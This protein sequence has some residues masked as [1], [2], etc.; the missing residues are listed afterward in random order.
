M[1]ILLLA[2]TE[3]EIAPTFDRLRLTAIKKDEKVFQTT[4]HLVHPLITGIGAVATT[5][6]LCKAL[7]ERPDV[8]IQAGV[9]GAFDFSMPLGTVV[10]VRT[11]VFADLAVEESD[12]HLKD[13]FKLGLL[14]PDEAPYSGQVL[15]NPT[16]TL[17]KNLNQVNGLT[18]QTVHGQ[19]HSIAA[20]RKRYPG[21][22]VESMEGAALFYGCILEK[23]PFFQI[24]AIS[25][26][27]EPR[28]REK[29][30]MEKAI[31]NLNEVMVDFLF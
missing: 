30:E 11:E 14:K 29:W 26:Y 3:F 27:V 10:E 5:W 15:T 24:R 19:S 4:K 1:K 16:P 13:F 20:I 31:Q 12:G 28:N 8:V 23:I 6:H 18:A 2:A 21:V 7:C 9:G 17:F 22:Q 25:N